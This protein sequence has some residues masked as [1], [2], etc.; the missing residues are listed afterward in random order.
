MIFRRG[1]ALFNLLILFSIIAAA[2][3]DTV[4]NQSDTHNLKQGWWKKSYPNGR[5]MYKGFFK[6]DKPAGDMFRYYETGELKAA[7]VYDRNG[8]YAHA[9]LFYADGQL[10]ATGVFCNS[11]KDSTWCYYSYYDHSL[12]TKEIYSKGKRNGPMINY[13]NNGNPSEKITWVNDKKDGP[14]EQFFAN[15]TPKLKATYKDGQLD[16]EFNVNYESGKPYLK[17]G[18]RNS[19]REGKWIFFNEDG[20]TDMELTYQMG[21][22]PDAEKLDARQQELFRMIEENKGKFE[23]PDETNF[24]TP[25]GR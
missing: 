10:A 2:Q 14:W 4:F 3:T 7:M 8:E 25:A 18:Y 12:T 6:D 5:L 20:T 24:L 15:N 19:L 22:T 11:L 16:G 1:Y 17:G 9:R 13:Y 23:E 21:N